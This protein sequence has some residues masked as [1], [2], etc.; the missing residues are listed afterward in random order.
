[1]A[2]RDAAACL[3]ALLKE[4]PAFHGQTAAG[5]K[6][7][8]LAGGVLDWI[9]S[10]MPENART[11]ETG[12]GYSTVAFACSSAGHTVISPYAGEH[13]L[14]AEWC[15]GHGVGTEHVKF[16]AQPSRE[17]VPQ[18]GAG[19]LDMVLIDGAHEFPVPFIDWYYTAECVKKGGY[20]LVDDVQLPTGYILKDF[21]SAEEGR[22]VFEEQVR[23]TSIFRK[24]TEASVAYEVNFEEQ[25]WC[26]RDFSLKGRIKR[27]LRGLVGQ[28]K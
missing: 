21:L 9:A 28:G 19:P 3:Q 1:M 15:A 4:M 2:M 6:N 25:P 17:V 24:V 20:V 12:C 16:I 22:W 23:L 11:L 18:L 14:I 13:R 8:A 5:T 7:Y 26:L 27:K 10:H